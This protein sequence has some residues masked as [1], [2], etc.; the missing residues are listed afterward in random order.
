MSPTSHV[1]P[2][3]S[4][5]PSPTPGAAFYLR[6]WY[7]QALPPNVTFNWLPVLTIADGTVIDGNVA[8]PMI[9]PGPLVV[10]PNARWISDA[11]I[12]AIIDEATRLGL[13]TDRTDFTGGGVMP[14]G[15]S[16]QLEL[17]VDGVRRILTGNPDVAPACTR[18]PCDAAPGSPAAFAAFWAELTNLDPLLGG[19]LGAF[20]PFQPERIALLFTAPV[21]A[22]PGLGQPQVPWPLDSTFDAV[23]VEFPGQQGA[24]CVTLSGDDL[25][26]LW[27]ALLS[28]NQLTTFVDNADSSRSF[29]VAVLVPGEDSPCP[30][31]PA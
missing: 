11:G 23:G 5:S 30:D 28:A 4:P 31:A 8:I 25:A 10:V 22:E 13:L 7:T 6:A 18:P 9:Y 24:R 3:P 21:P 16:G 20:V 12:A 15:R 1:T 29:V 19:E 14:G 26:A 27:P 17:L 2:T